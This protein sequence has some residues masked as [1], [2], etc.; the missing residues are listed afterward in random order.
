MPN[1]RLKPVQSGAGSHGDE[2]L[3]CAFSPNGR[4]VIS[5]G[6]D[7]HLRV[8]DPESAGFRNAVAVSSKPVSAVAVTPDGKQFLTGSVEGLLGRWD[9]ATLDKY[10]TFLVHTRPVS[11]I[12]IVDLGQTI[13]TGSWDHKLSIWQG[14]V[15]ARSLA[16]HRDVV[17]GCQ[18]TLDEAQLL[19]WSY[20]ESLA[21]WDL[22]Q[23]REPVM[24]SGH[25]NGVLSGAISP[26]KRWIASGGRDGSVI[27]WD[28]SAQDEVAGLQCEGEIRY[29]GFLRSGRWLVVAD[30]TGRVGMYSVPELE[31]RASVQTYLAIQCGAL[32]ASGAQLA[33]GCGDGLVHFVD[34]DGFDDAPLLT[35]VYQEVRQTSKGLGRVLGK[36]R[37]EVFFQ[38]LC[39]ACMA[40]FELPA[41]PPGTELACAGCRRAIRVAHVLS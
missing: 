3:A 7:G 15:V 36:R 26:D 23:P 32:S 10:T 19:S 1:L 35:C 2:V 37:A 4:L 30:M 21:L 25:A 6:W 40:M 41:A 22:K 38:G 39:P 13:I 17:A 28:V 5:G 31:G 20:D 27:L 8:W 33:L 24:F 34:V 11:C 14:T 9:A 12:A 16:G 29:C 18:A